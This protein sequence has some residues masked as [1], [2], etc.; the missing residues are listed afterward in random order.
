M[1]AKIII[2]TLAIVIIGV[3]LFWLV[4]KYSRGGEFGFRDVV[5]NPR[6][7]Q[8]MVE[9]NAK[10]ES[11][12]LPNWSAKEIEKQVRQYVFT[13][14][15]EE[16]VRPLGNVLKALSPQTHEPLMGILRDHSNQEA[17]SELREERYYKRAPVMR[18]CDLFAG[19]MPEE[20]VNL[21]KPF[22][23][24]KSDEIRK[25]C[26]LAVA[27]SG[28][29]IALPSIV[30]ALKDEDEYVRSYTLI[31]LKRALE[32]KA[33][34]NEL[35]AGVLAELEA[36][37][38][39]NREVEEC[40]QLLS[41][42]DAA[43]A[44]DFLTSEAVLSPHTKAIHEVIRTIREFQ[45]QVPRERVLELYDEISKREMKYPNDY[46]IGELLALLGT[47][48]NP[49]DETLL[50]EKS[51]HSEKK[52]SDGAATGLLSYHGLGDFKKK[53][54][55]E[56]ASDNKTLTK[57]QQMYLA[58]YMLDAEINNGGHSQYFFNSTGDDWQNALD[59]LKAMGMED[60]AAVFQRSLD[61]FGAKGPSSDRKTRQTQLSKI[62]RKHEA[63][64]NKLDSQYYDSKE[65]VEVGLI[66]FVIQNAPKF[67]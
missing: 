52:V 39:T 17:L 45:F 58:V 57:E 44:K 28:L 64:F 37:I 24:H 26:M 4:K 49:L 13:K 46:A 67:Q 53:I 25:E 62:Y 65:S 48:H 61:Y 32:A 56:E 50:E 1:T 2:A 34:S 5:R 60:R 51:R 10:P 63:D 29:G 9:E 18:I 12:R 21:L 27:Q 59:G 33:L 22:L 11:K 42:I 8:E 23:E 14:G 41:L 66:R 35:S 31:G 55:N 36:S 54:W 40:S 7:W 30:S 43:R 16:D 3:V 19:S 20:A 6:I 15:D 38:L 47:M